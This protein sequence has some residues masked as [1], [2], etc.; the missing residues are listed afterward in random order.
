MDTGISSLSVTDPLS[1]LSLNGAPPT[2]FSGHVMRVQAGIRLSSLEHYQWW[3]CSLSKERR[4]YMQGWS[5]L[6]QA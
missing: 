4:A 6:G 5:R 3:V 1:W 2:L